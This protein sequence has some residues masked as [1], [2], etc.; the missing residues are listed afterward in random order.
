MLNRHQRLRESS[1]KPVTLVFALT[2]I[3]WMLIPVTASAQVDNIVHGYAGAETGDWGGKNGAVIGPADNSCAN[4]GAVGKVNLVSNFG[5]SIPLDATITEVR[6]FT[7][8][9]A[10][11]VQNV[12]VQLA[13]NAAV[14]P[15]TT[16]GNVVQY[17]F[18]DVGS[19]NCASTIVS[20]IGNGLGFWGLGSLDPAVVNSTNFGMVF[21]TPP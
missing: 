12:D 3:F 13:S 21:T 1:V 8:A 17:P 4:M 10:G 11:S 6:A 5:F 14:E 20:D 18:P 7:K 2:L 15:P 9:G 19:G 16:I